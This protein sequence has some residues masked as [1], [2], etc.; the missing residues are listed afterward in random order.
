VI[1]TGSY[2]QI[3]AFR[4]LE[5]AAGSNWRSRRHLRIAGLPKARGDYIPIQRVDV[6]DQATANRY[7]DGSMSFIVKTPAR[8]RTE[9]DK[10][11]AQ[12]R[13][14]LREARGQCRAARVEAKR[15][16][17]MEVSGRGECSSRSLIE[18]MRREGFEL[19][20][21]RVPAWC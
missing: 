14:A 7:A 19:S 9:G 6:P 21:V 3:M 13:D 12:I 5:T 16:D 1:E 20:G 15:R 4:G 2:Y 8:R 18:T 10:V 11:T 17:A